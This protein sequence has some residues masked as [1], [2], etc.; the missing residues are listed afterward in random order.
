MR[1]VQFMQ[2]NALIAEGKLQEKRTS[3]NNSNIES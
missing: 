3:K 2:T 1:S